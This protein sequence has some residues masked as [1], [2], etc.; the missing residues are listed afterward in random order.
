MTFIEDGFKDC[1]DDMAEVNLKDG[2]FDDSDAGIKD[3]TTKEKEKYSFTVGEKEQLSLA[4]KSVK[5]LADL[6]NR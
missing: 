5:I 1:C 4:T 6:R 3:W 2:F